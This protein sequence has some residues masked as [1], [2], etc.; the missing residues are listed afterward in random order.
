[1]GTKEG[2]ERSK[3]DGSEKFSLLFSNEKGRQGKFFTVTGLLRQTKSFFWS[4]KMVFHLLLLLFFSLFLEF[5]FL[6]R[7]HLSFS[8]VSLFFAMLVFLVVD[9]LSS[10]K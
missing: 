7:F 8:L 6:L 2:K 1:L 5:S 9:L 3:T 4:S 10:Q